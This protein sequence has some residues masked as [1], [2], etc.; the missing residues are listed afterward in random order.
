VSTLTKA[1]ELRYE[2]IHAMPCIACR[3]AKHV[4][5]CGRTEAHH[6]VDKGYRR[7]SGGNQATLPLGGWHHRGEPPKGHTVKSATAKWGPSLFHESKR[8]HATYGSQRQLLARVNEEIG[9]AA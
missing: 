4:V 3:I 2:Q 7:L 6:L 8:F 1:D 5:Q 9:V